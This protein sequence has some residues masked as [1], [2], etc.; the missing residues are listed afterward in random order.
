MY[1]LQLLTNN[2]TDVALGQ[3]QGELRKVAK[4]YLKYMRETG[5]EE[6]ALIDENIEQWWESNKHKYKED[7]KLFMIKEAL[8]RMDWAIK[9][10]SDD[11]PDRTQW[12][13]SRAE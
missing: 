10:Y 4:D 3:A 8:L 5:Q 13:R 9:R 2:T 6:E 7:H 1:T 11:I 12:M